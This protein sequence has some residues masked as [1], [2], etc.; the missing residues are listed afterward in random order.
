MVGCKSLPW[1]KKPASV[2]VGGATVIAP[3]EVGKAATIDSREV[4]GQ[5][6]I[7]AGTQ[8]TVTQIPVTPD[9]PAK[10]VTEWR[11]TQPANFMS[12]DAHTVANSGTTDNTQALKK[13]DIDSRQPFLYFG[14]GAVVAGVVLI[15]MGWPNIG[16]LSFVAAG[17]LLLLWK[18]SDVSSNLLFGVV[19]IVGTGFGIWWGHTHA[20]KNQTTSTTSIAA[21]TSSTSTVPKT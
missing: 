13:L 20:E 8:I 1:A 17:I 14:V 15:G 11:F 16:K 3:A 6:A 19:A 9:S 18:V 2:T 5:L 10:T 7:P 21:T 12:F 4:K